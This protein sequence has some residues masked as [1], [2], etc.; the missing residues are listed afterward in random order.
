MKNHLKTATAILALLLSIVTLMCSKDQ[1]EK[2]EMTQSTEKTVVNPFFEDFTTPFET[3][4]FRVIKTEHFL[5]AMKK[6]IEEQN[7]EIEAITSNPE[8][9]TFKNT[10]DAMARTGNLL[11]KVQGVFSS[12]SSA[13][14]NDEMQKVAQQ[15]QPLLTQHTD[16]IWLNRDLFQRV[17]KVYENRESEQLS[18]EEAMLLEKTYKK[19][20]RGGANLTGEKMER[21]KAINKELATLSLKFGEHVLADN[22]AFELIIDN[23]ADLAGLP[24]SAKAAAA[25]A[26]GQAGKWK[27]TL[28]KP[29]LIPFL[30]YSDIRP[31]RE[32]MF[33]GYINRGDN[34]NANNNSDVLL[35]IAKLRLE[36][37]NLLGFPTHAHYILDDNMAK[38]P[39]KVYELMD[40]VWKPALKRAKE[41]AAELQEMI[42]ASGETFKLEPW[43]WWYYAEKLKKKKYD[44]DE[45]MIRPYF[46]LENVIQGAFD[47]CNKL[48]GITFTARPDIP[49][50]HKDAKAYEVKNS[51][52]SHIGVLFVDYFPRPSKR[53]GAWM[54]AFRKQSENVSPVIYNVG[55]FTKPT[56]DTPSL[57]TVDEVKTLFHELGHALHGLL[58]NCRYRALSGTAVARDFVEMPSQVME[59]WAMHPEVLKLYAVHYQT[60]EP[61]PDA[62]IEKITNSGHFNQGFATAEFMAAAY[63]DMDWHTQTSFDGVEPGEFETK[64]MQKIGLIPEIVVRYRSPYFNH[65]FSGGYSAGYYAYLWAEVLDADAFEAFLENGVFDP[66]TASS[67]KDNILSKGGTEDPMKLY[68]DFRG[69]EPGID[70]LLKRRGF[71]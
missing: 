71:K 14:A 48:W 12:Y 59:N 55:N 7:R 23:E 13:M 19:F 20:V 54:D 32:K 31:L 60:S 42:N 3:P 29:S 25:E 18:G 22:N 4:D 39:E 68:K 70:P 26:S 24:D 40:Q 6:G 27:F 9:P 46:K 43:D 57:L 11:N 41:E 51:D 28:D 33:K 45:E 58:S 1:A 66:A 47:V 21:F 38:T 16:S 69:R 8:E 64:S 35:Q 61:I 34:D 65:I 62:L 10:V 53:G 30:T 52:G 36:K 15:I 44:L 17:K 5:P 49:V 67:F 2:K 37:A 56:A 50:Y 63:L